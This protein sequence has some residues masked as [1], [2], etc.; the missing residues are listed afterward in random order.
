MRVALTTLGCKV[1]QYDTATIETHLRCA[2]CEIVSFA[3][4]AD[5]YVVNSCT[6][7]DRA[8][9]ESRQLARRARRIN[10]AA[11]VIMTGCFAQINPHGAAIPEVDH[12]VGLNRLPDLIRA[13]RG[14]M[15]AGERIA[16]D[17]L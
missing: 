14:E 17:D 4:P 13:V 12:V 3:S 5:V 6:V 2:G 11:R 15:A 16:V 7:T 8:D 9:A 1:N 10:P